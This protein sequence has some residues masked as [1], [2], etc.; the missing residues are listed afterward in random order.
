MA[1]RGSYW[2]PPHQIPAERC[3]RCSTC[4]IGFLA[5][6]PHD[7]EDGWLFPQT[8]L[9]FA[10]GDH[11]VPGFLWGFVWRGQDGST[12]DV[13]F[14]GGFRLTRSS[15]RCKATRCTKCGGVTAQFAETR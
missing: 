3:R 5:D 15:R 11:F 4:R 1:R 7:V 6:C 8:A 9:R 12:P 2:S 14:K 10:K 13:V